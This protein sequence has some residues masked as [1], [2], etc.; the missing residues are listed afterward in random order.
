MHGCEE[1]CRLTSGGGLSGLCLGVCSTVHGLRVSCSER[2]LG[3]VLLSVCYR[4]RG[5]K[6]SRTIPR[7]H[8]P[9]RPRPNNRDFR[10]VARAPR[11]SSDHLSQEWMLG[12][13]QVKE[14]L[15]AC[16]PSI[17]YVHSAGLDRSCPTVITVIDLRLN[18]HLWL[19]SRVAKVPGR[20]SALSGVVCR[21]L[22]RPCSL[23]TECIAAISQAGCV[24]Y[25][26]RSSGR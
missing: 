14:F 26:K 13:A 10:C 3:S 21:L 4:W 22:E 7:H 25:N 8:G 19:R 1:C 20:E 16:C 5:L 9:R 15:P 6:W 17:H 23:L 12:P 18:T 11:P 2:S 24:R